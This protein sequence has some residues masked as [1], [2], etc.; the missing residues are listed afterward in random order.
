MIMKIRTAE[1]TPDSRPEII[2][3]NLYMLTYFKSKHQCDEM[4]ACM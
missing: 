1:N 2:N 4:Y 3:K